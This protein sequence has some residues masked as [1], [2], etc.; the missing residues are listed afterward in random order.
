[1]QLILYF[2]KCF[3]PTANKL[4]RAALV[5][6]PLRSMGEVNPSIIFYAVL[7]VGQ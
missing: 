2:E 1:M 4:K 3:R 6:L 7:S 5:I